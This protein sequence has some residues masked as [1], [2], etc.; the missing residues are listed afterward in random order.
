MNPV[1]KTQE[2]TNKLGDS[3]SKAAKT[4]QTI[5]MSYKM[6]DKTNK[7]FDGTNKMTNKTSNEMTNEMTDKTN[8]KTANAKETTNK[9]AKTN[10]DATNEMKQDD[11]IGTY[12][13]VVMQ[14]GVPTRH[15]MSMQIMER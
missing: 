7:T 5:I 3:A 9:V 1:D 2:V 11:H 15:T 12:H 10:D 8:K 14:R 13:D 4:N 6:I